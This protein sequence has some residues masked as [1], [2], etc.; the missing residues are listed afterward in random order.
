M[1]KID[2]CPTFFFVVYT[3]EP[4]MNSVQGREDTGWNKYLINKLNVKEKGWLSFTHVYIRSR[5]FFERFLKDLCLMC[6]I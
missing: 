1:P 2:Y 4:C 5:T 6:D 3:K